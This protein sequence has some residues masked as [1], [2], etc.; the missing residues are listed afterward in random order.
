MEPWVGEAT[1]KPGVSLCRFLRGVWGPA[2]S[3][4]GPAPW[5]KR[6][7]GE[8]QLEQDL[9]GGCSI[10][11]HRPL[12]GWWVGRSCMGRRTPTASAARSP[13]SS[14]GTVTEGPGTWPGMG[15]RVLLVSQ[16]GGEAGWSVSVGH[17]A[18]VSFCVYKG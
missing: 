17:L 11:A 7:E 16:L 3:R 2:T 4:R 5:L 8:R 13:G 14:T 1:L 18:R 12:W 10:R 6:P 9:G 15:Q